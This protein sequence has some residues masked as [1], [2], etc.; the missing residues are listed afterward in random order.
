MPSSR[1]VSLRLGSFTCYPLWPPLLG[2]REEQTPPASIC[3][4]PRASFLITARR[5]I[6]S[7]ILLLA[8]VNP[9]SLLRAAFASAPACGSISNSTGG[10][11]VPNGS[12]GALSYGNF[13]FCCVESHSGKH[14][15]TL[16]TAEGGCATPSQDH[17]RGRR[18]HTF[19]FVH[20]RG[21][22]CHT[23]SASS[24]AEGGCATW[25][26]FGLH[27]VL[28]E[29]SEI[30]IPPQS[31]AP[32]ETRPGSLRH[33]RHLSALGTPAPCPGPGN[34]ALPA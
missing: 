4:N 9:T 34:E 19:S 24:T 3:I 8:A 14:P 29:S 27:N 17:S 22:R 2:D 12:S 5:F 6:L 10:T 11:A 21:R 13:G 20:R 32:R 18:C 15:L 23:N 1:E 28:I 26:V 16:S 33:L 7:I 30:S 25:F 31:S